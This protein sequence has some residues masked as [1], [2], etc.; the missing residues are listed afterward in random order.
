MSRYAAPPL[1]SVSVPT[2]SAGPRHA[3]L[4]S[5]RPNLQ[6]VSL[7]GGARRN[8]PRAGGVAWAARVENSP[9]RLAR[10]APL[11]LSL[12][13]AERYGERSDRRSSRWRAYAS[14]ERN[15]APERSEDNFQEGH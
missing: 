4:T 10:G 3:P 13:R 12:A 9:I 5:P 2:D 14:A 11:P 1:R 6:A 7:C 15:A 8:S